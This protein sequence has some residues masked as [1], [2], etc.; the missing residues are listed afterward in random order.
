MKAGPDSYEQQRLVYNQLITWSM[1]GVLIFCWI[2]PMTAQSLFKEGEDWYTRRASGADSFRTS[3]TN[4]DKAI[5][6]FESTE[7]EEDDGYTPQ[8]AINLLQAYYFK[9]IYTDIDGSEQKRAF[10]KA[11]ALG[12]K[13]L[14]QY[15]QSAAIWYWY[16]KNLIEW[17]RMHNLWQTSIDRTD[18]KMRNAAQQ[19]IALDSTYQEGGGYRLLAQIHYETPSILLVKGWP[20]KD[21]ALKLIQKAMKVAPKNH[22]NQLFYAR[23]LLHFGRNTEAKTQLQHILDMNPRD[24][25]LVEDRYLKHQAEHLWQQHIE[26]SG[27]EE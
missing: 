14:E 17:D 11:R 6:A 26:Q 23:M 16:C 1:L 9:G 13:M 18:G 7:Q 3:S 19:V 12:E 24:S 21:E 27:E 5:T 4:I 22:A 8:P 25:H 20:S 10:D 15:P 2:P